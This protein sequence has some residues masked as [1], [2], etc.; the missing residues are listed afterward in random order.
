MRLCKCGRVI[1]VGAFTC[2]LCMGSLAREHE[3]HTYETV[4]VTN[5]AVRATPSGFTIS[6]AA[7]GFVSDDVLVSDVVTSAVTFVNI[8][9]T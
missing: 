5:A 1:A 2:L 7:G 3:P 4:G 9:A 8:R 6:G